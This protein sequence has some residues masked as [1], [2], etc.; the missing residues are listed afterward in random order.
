MANKIQV[1]RGTAAQAAAVT[2]DA[3][4]LGWLTDTLRLIVGD[5]ATAGGR[6][7]QMA[8]QAVACTTLDASGKI[9]CTDATDATNLTTASVVLSGGLAVTK[10]L[11]VGGA[12]TFSENVT[13]ATGKSLTVD[14]ITATAASVTVS[15]PLSVAVA[16][17]SQFNKYMQVLT[18]DLQAADWLQFNFGRDI[19]TS[20]NSAEMNFVY[21]GSGSTSNKLRL[22]LFGAIDGLELDGNGDVTSQG[23]VTVATGKTLTVDTI[24]ATASSVTFSK[25]INVSAGKIN[26]GTALP[27]S[28]ADFAAVR[29]F[30][31]TAFV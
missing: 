27:A 2:L 26:S 8:G 6:Q 11:R 4:E 13:I 30:L 5:G 10:Q 21:A 16:R 1:R 7:V 22:S 14:T 17:A 24:T 28:F 18:S 12:A 20:Y 23:N 29:T 31:A 19:S 25:V 15:K 9:V 3:G